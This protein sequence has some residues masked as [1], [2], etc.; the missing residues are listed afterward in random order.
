MERLLSK[1]KYLSGLQCRKKLWL[2]IYQPQKAKQAGHF[3]EMVLQRG[4]D[5]GKSARERFPGGILIEAP[6]HDIKAA[7][8]ETETHLAGAK[9]GGGSR[10]RQDSTPILF[11]PAFLHN[12]LFCRVDI[13]VPAGEEWDIIE[14]KSTLDIQDIQLPDAAV[15]KYILEGAGLQVRNTCIMHLNRECRYPDLS[16]LFRIEK[17]DSLI[18]DE[19]ETVP[20]AAAAFFTVMQERE[21]PMVPAGDH[22]RSPYECAFID[23][24]WR[25]VPAPSLYNIR[26][27]KKEKR[28]E[29]TGRGIYSVFDIPG[30]Y[31]LSPNEQ[32]QVKM[33]RSGKA[34][35][36]TAAIRKQLAALTF[37]LYFLDFETDNPAVP[38]YEGMAPY[39]QVPF[40]YSLHILRKNGELEHREYLHTDSSDPRRPLAEQLAMDIKAASR[41]ATLIAYYAVFEKNVITGLARHFPDLAPDLEPAVKRFWDLLDIFK[42]HYRHPG[43]L[44]SNSLKSVLPVIVPEMGYAALDVQN[45][46]E[47]QMAWNA[48]LD[49]ELSEREKRR[50]EEALRVYCRQ[51][52]LAMVKIYEELKKI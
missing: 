6:Y 31:P 16:D 1:S 32:E 51:D 13:L 30:D 10:N 25:D 49:P 37:P 39:Q 7:L 45:G 8:T 28:E 14:V 40:Q 23:Y 44:G 52:T 27:L 22:C 11:E 50:M 26:R 9:H 17:V 20:R 19:L 42:K 38:R 29:L 4:T 15:Q 24:C 46:S 43:F 18:Q 3:T 41:G 2:S 21:E 36:D 12:G 48:L 35:I 47:A 34:K 5:I 33:Y